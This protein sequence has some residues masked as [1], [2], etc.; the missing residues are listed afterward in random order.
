MVYFAD[1]KKFDGLP[2]SEIKCI[3]LFDTLMVDWSYPEIQPYLI[4]YYLSSKNL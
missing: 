2:E 3:E 1:I 4:E